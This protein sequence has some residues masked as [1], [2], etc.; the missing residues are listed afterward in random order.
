MYPIETIHATSGYNTEPRLQSTDNSYYVKTFESMKNYFR[1]FSLSG[2]SPSISI[3]RM[4]GI[5]AIMACGFGLSSRELLAQPPWGD[6]PPPWASRESG[7]RE[8]GWRSG[9]GGGF[10]PA[11]MIQQFDT[12]GNQMIDMDEMQ[13][14]ARFMLDRMARDNPSIDLTKPVPISKI[15]EAMESRMRGGPGGPMGGGSEMSE[16][17]GVPV[18]EKPLV[19]D[20][21]TAEATEPLPGFGKDA[22]KFSVKVE[23]RDLNEASDRISRYD[24][25]KDQQLSEEELKDGR[26]ADSPMQYDRNRDSKLNKQELAVRYAR[27]RIKSESDSKAKEA[28]KQVAN[29]LPKE[30]GDKPEVVDPWKT[31]AHYRITPKVGKLSKVQGTQGWFATSDNDGDGQVMMHEFA[32]NWDDSTVEEFRRFDTNLDGT[33]T[34]A[35]LLVSVK[36]GIMRGSVAVAA[37]TAT[38]STPSAGNA[39]GG[40]G[41]FDSEGVEPRWIKFCEKALVALDRDKNYRVTADEWPASNGEFNSTDSN[42]DGV[43]SMLEYYIKRKEL[44]K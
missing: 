41:Q 29:V 18:E 1:L 15:T 16:E 11:R 31:Q 44:K 5:S 33:I 6:G 27:K 22:D 14:P 19:P 24:K 23:E 30:G 7:S 9:R 28:G 32:S 20:F 26:W 34:T 25:N 35:E 12:N 2:S 17:D 36:K 38:A 37:P 43:I 21:G 39:S 4:L 13:G 8:G 10:D 40:S 42:Q 3:G